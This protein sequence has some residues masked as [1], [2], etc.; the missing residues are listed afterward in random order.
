M[1]TDGQNF[2][3]R[4]ESLESLLK[5]LEAQKTAEGRGRVLAIITRMLRSS[6]EVARQMADGRGLA[7]TMQLL[8]ENERET[9]YV[10]NMVAMTV[11][12]AE[13]RAAVPRMFEERVDERMKDMMFQ[14]TGQKDIFHNAQR[15]FS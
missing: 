10:A 9:V 7:L 15:V 12:L 11:A 8:S 13:H 2:S 3:I 6:E 4:S 5:L 14:Y 1:E